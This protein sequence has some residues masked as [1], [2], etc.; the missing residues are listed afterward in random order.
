M[1]RLGEQ[2]R[3]GY[4]K[5]LL[6][7]SQPKRVK[8][9]LLSFSSAS[10]KADLK[11]RIN[12]LV[13]KPYMKKATALVLAFALCVITACTFTGKPDEDQTMDNKQNETESKQ[14]ETEPEEETEG[15]ISLEEW[16]AGE[17]P[18]VQPVAVPEYLEIMHSK[19]KGG[20]SGCFWMP[21]FYSTDDLDNEYWDSFIFYEYTSA[22]G[23]EKVRMDDD[24]SYNKVPEQDVR[25]LVYER[26]G[27]EFPDFHPRYQDLAEGETGVFYDEGYYYVGMSDFPDIG[28]AV[29]DFQTSG[30]MMTATFA[31]A[32]FYYYKIFNL[33]SADNELGYI[34]KSITYE[35]VDTTDNIS[36]ISREIKNEYIRDILDYSWFGNSI[37]YNRAYFLY[38]IDNDGYPEF[39]IREDNGCLGIYG[40]KD[41][42]YSQTVG[43]VY[44]TF[45][46]NKDDG[47]IFA[48]RR[49]DKVKVYKISMVPVI[50][51]YKEKTLSD[52]TAI[53]REISI[54]E[55]M[56]NRTNGFTYTARPVY[57]IIKE[58]IYSGKADG[59]TISGEP[60]QL[61]SIY[62][63]SAIQNYPWP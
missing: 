1:L 37:D 11:E 12:M 33:E 36:D 24:G 53:S 35:G 59:Y 55:M 47:I 28:Y 20:L 26:F 5:A 51:Y 45:Y 17:L 63:I 60:L 54:K 61:Y 40:Y 49:K 57:E 50:H 58:E 18:E 41:G 27:V 8:A 62:D 30:D 13:N 39:F 43:N 38:D 23:Y 6:E 29:I 25:M 21:G 10:N 34:I 46:G 19:I 3:L 4:G 7:L 42:Y 2:A 15:G 56:G 14:Q 31:T 44:G 22:D 9:Y 32:P 16:E 52:G 48:D